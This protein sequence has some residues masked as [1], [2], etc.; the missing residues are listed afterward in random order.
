MLIVEYDTSIEHWNKWRGK[1]IIPNVD[2]FWLWLEFV[3][4]LFEMLSDFL[5]NY[6]SDASKNTNLIMFSQLEILGSYS[7]P[8]CVILLSFDLQTNGSLLDCFLSGCKLF[9]YL[10]SNSSENSQTNLQTK[11]R[12]GAS[13]I[14]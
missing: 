8:C 1:Q 3:F 13:S 9:N 12:L 4:I 2:C 6:V 14:E 5:S 7:F 10:T 11:I